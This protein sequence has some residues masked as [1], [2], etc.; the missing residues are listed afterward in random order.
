MLL[1][2]DQIISYEKNAKCYNI[3]KNANQVGKIYIPVE[4]T[5]V[6]L[7]ICAGIL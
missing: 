4:I 7:I 6:G 5:H 3:V 1:C 2:K